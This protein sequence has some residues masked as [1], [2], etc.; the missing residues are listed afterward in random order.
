MPTV[1]RFRAFRLHFFSNEGQE[2]PHIHV[3]RGD[4]TCKFWLRPVRLAY[5]DGMRVDE[6][7]QLERFIRA[8]EDD[9]EDK[10]YDYFS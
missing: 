8:H 3:R 9:I 6:L 2:P 10:W 1:Y 7:T 4:D 5:N